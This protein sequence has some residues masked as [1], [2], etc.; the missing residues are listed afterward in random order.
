M[1]ATEPA[2]RADVNVS[3]ATGN[4]RFQLSINGRV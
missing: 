1:P 3:I 4:G 2:F